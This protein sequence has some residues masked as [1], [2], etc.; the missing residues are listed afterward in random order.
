M[1]IRKCIEMNLSKTFIPGRVGNYNTKK[2]EFYIDKEFLCDEYIPQ[3]LDK[4][5]I[6]HQSCQADTSNH[7][8]KGYNLYPKL[9]IIPGRVVLSRQEL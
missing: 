6:S 3:K 1:I 4:T 8:Q 5:S 2:Y 7:K 9:G